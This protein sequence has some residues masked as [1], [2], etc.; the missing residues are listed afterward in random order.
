MCAPR[1]FSRCL[2]R[3]VV[4]CRC[5]RRSARV[6]CVCRDHP[7]HTRAANTKN[8]NKGFHAALRALCDETGT[9]LIIDETHT[10]SAGP[11]EVLVAAWGWVLCVCVC[12]CVCRESERDREKRAGVSF[13]QRR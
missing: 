8:N 3:A 2:L 11:G 9:L 7:P 6:L 1:R 13:Q 4:G 5:P 10:I 12:V